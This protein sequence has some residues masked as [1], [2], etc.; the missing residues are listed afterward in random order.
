MPV[1]ALT[2]GFGRE[3]YLRE[4]HSQHLRSLGISIN[5]VAAVL[6]PIL[7]PAEEVYTGYSTY[8]ERCYNTRA[9]VLSCGTALLADFD[10][11]GVIQ[12]F[13]IVNEPAEYIE[14]LKQ[15]LRA[16][17]ELGDFFIADWNHDIAVP[18]N[19]NDKLRDYLSGAAFD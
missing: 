14:Q 8:R 5:S 13:W 7:E 1:S 3:W 9:W 15:A 6:D 2:S 19:D 16:L 10:E 11:T 17:G 12:H 18:C 4:D